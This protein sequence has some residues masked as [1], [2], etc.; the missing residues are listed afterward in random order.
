MWRAAIASALLALVVAPGAQAALPTHTVTVSHVQGH[1]KVTFGLQGE[2]GW[3]YDEIEIADS[4][5]V[6]SDYHFFAENVVEWEYMSHEPTS[7]EWLSEYRL[8]PGTYYVRL[9]GGKE[10]CYECW[11]ATGHRVLTI[12]AEPIVLRAV[13][14]DGYRT[15][16]TRT[17][18]SLEIEVCGDEADF[19]YQITELNRN[20]QGYALRQTRKSG[21]GHHYGSDAGCATDY[22]SM[23]SR[24]THQRGMKH[25]IVVQVNGVSRSA[26]IAWQ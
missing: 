15:I 14:V 12:P 17:S 4:P 23:T 3:Y 10:D 6:A 1:P 19:R 11:F 13:S 18:Y 16:G 26:T 22:V 20:R 25:Q 9:F 7:G 8:S 24:V 21:T 5:E 2:P